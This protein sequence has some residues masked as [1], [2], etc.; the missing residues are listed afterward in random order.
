[1]YA[2]LDY[3]DLAGWR[4][5]VDYPLDLPQG[6][7]GMRLWLGFA[8]KKLNT[9]T[10]DIALRE[11]RLRL[12]R[13]LPMLELA[14]LN[15]RLSGR[16]PKSGFEVASRK[17]ALATRDGITLLPT[18]FTLRWTPAMGKQPAQG[19]MSANGL[20]LDVLTRLAGFLPLDEG[21]R[22]TLADYAPRGRIFDL[23]LGW[24]G[25][26]GALSNFNVRARFENLGLAPRATPRASTA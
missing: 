16:L 23:K 20:D 13:G 26:S 1:V 19:E 8:E 7:G 9:L 15:G 10:A 6:A 25:E 5:W 17:L 18:D 2:E 14:H 11:V 3:A 21:T 4:A 24:K 12:A 22:K